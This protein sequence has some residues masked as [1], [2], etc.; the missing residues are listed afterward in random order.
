MHEM[1]LNVTIREM[2]IKTTMSITSHLWE[3][4]LTKRQEIVSV[5]EDVEKSE[6]LYTVGGNANWYSHDRE[7]NESSKS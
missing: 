7:K 4:V 2:Q 3:W 5:G 6:P 1:M